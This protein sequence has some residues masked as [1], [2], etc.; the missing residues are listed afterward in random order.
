MFCDKSGTKFNHN[1]TYALFKY[2]AEE[3]TFRL[4]GPKEM[5][6]HVAGHYWNRHRSGLPHQLIAKE[7][8]KDMGLEARLGDAVKQLELPGIREV[9]DEQLQA[10]SDELV[11]LT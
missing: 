10:L 11:S 5:S 1:R 3:E 8:A 9:T 4:S 6:E 7:L 2:A